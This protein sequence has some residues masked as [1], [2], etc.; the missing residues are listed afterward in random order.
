MDLP[1]PKAASVSYQPFVDRP[2]D[3]ARCCCDKCGLSIMVAQAPRPLVCPFCQRRV[4]QTP[5]QVP[6]LSPEAVSR[7]LKKAQASLRPR[8]ARPR[9]WVVLS[10]AAAGILL[11]STA[12]YFQL[13]NIE[14]YWYAPLVNL[15]SLVVGIFIVSRFVIAAFYSPPPDV[16][17]EPKVTIIVPCCNEVDAIAKTITRIYAEGYPHDKLEVIAVNDG[18]TD[19]TLSEML[20]VQAQFPSL[21]VV[22]FEQNHGLALGMTVCTILAR[23]E[24]LIFVDSDTF[25]LPGSVRKICQGMADLRVGGVSGHTDVENVDTNIL[26]RM[27]DVRY[28]VSFKIMKAA[29]SVFATVSCLPGCFSAY[30]KICV[31]NALDRWLNRKFLGVYGAF[32]DDRSL[33]NLVLKDYRILYDAE[34]LATTIVPDRWGKYIRQQARWTRSWVREIFTASIFMWRKHPA[35]TIA[36]YAMMI[37][38]ILEPVVMVQAL[39]L[40]P[41]LYGQMMSYYIIGIIAI[42]MVWSLYYLEKTG[43]KSWWTGI[44]FTLTYAVF[45]SWQVYYALATMRRAPRWGTRG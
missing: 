16:G 34:A 29:E 21:V 41:L 20:R 44:V 12:I 2:R 42:T 18:S 30:R 40:G 5:Y 6:L 22:D 33:T 19:N 4:K 23:G 25:I 17:F 39:I 36:W 38:P 1:S 43:R 3:G 14:H 8:Q 26:T 35:A 28:Y 32:G 31:L 10:L 11:L 45:F 37:L 13:S 15:Y 7:S 27:Q 9:H 24:I